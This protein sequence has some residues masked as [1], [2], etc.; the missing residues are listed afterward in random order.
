MT[1]VHCK[2]T[3]TI[4]E[5]GFRERA[6]EMK[7]KRIGIEGERLIQASFFVVVSDLGEVGEAYLYPPR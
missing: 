4:K 6:I 7:R 3:I 1:E 5:I 2:D